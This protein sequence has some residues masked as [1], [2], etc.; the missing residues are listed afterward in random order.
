MNTQTTTMSLDTNYGKVLLFDSKYPDDVF[1]PSRM[2]DEEPEKPTDIWPA[3]MVSSEAKRRIH[4]QFRRL[5]YLNDVDGAEHEIE[6]GG[7]TITAVHHYESHAERGGDH[8]C[9]I[10][11]MVEKIDRDEIEII[12]V[13]DN[14]NEV[15][16][17]ALVKE[18]NQF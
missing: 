7:Y 14:V 5:F 2:N 8:Y 18:L 9:G 6:R 1:I 12:E 16:D 15:Y 10:W 11:E 4:E 17:F 13:Y 3:Y